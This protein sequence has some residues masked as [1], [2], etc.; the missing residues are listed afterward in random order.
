M[1]SWKRYYAEK[2]SGEF[3]N[4]VREIVLA[5]GDAAGSGSE[6]ENREKSVA[7]FRV[8]R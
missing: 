4:S 3:K 2:L 7:S 1:Y 6:R 8:R 5:I